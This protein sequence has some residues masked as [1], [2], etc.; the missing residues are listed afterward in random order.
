L[1]GVNRSRWLYHDA[2]MTAAAANERSKGP[3]ELAVAEKHSRQPHWPRPIF[4][5]P[6][7]ISAARGRYETGVIVFAVPRALFFTFLNGFPYIRPPACDRSD[8]GSRHQ[9]QDHH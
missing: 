6:P 3:S 9:Q 5:E 8:E 2:L 7:S 1:F 4:W